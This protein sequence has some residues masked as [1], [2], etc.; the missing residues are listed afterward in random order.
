MNI[1]DNIL[2]HHLKNVLFVSGTAY[3]G[4]TTM[5]KLIEGKYGFLRYRESTKFNEHLAYANKHYQPA[6]CY[7]RGDWQRFFNRPGLGKCLK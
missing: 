1:A 3:G 7:E 2:K 4:K 6:M 5:T